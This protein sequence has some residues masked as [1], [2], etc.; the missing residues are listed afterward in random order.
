MGFQDLVGARFGRLV[1]TTREASDRSGSI[2]WSCLCD[3]SGT[4]VVR[5]TSLRS[6]NTKSCGCLVGH[7]ARRGGR[8]PVHGLAG[9]RE[10]S[11][12]KQM[13]A[14]CRDKTHPAFDYYGGRGIEVCERWQ[15]NPTA[16]FADM[17]PRPGDHYSIDRVDND[18][19]YE[20]SNCRWA[21]PKEQRA[22]QRRITLHFRGE[23]HTVEEWAATTGIALFA[24]YHRIRRDW[25]VERILTTPSRRN[26]S[27]VE[28]ETLR[29]SALAGET[30]HALANEYGVSEAQVSRI[31]NCRSQ[32]G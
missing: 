14:R 16:F 29:A 7:R 22:N 18:G 5:A 12:W 30:R 1:V 11:S 6:G 21:T 32:S 31:I 20:P 19:N 24:I 26:L 23:T 15:N 9:T 8:K 28:A 3:C 17:G 4:I 27:R 13:L 2:R 25:P 10:Y